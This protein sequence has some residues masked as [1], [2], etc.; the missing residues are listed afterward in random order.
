MGKRFFNPR[1][2]ELY[3]EGFIN[4]KKLLVLGASHYCL[5]SNRPDAFKCPVW[6]ECTS[7]E[8]RDSSKFN[9]C[10]PAYEANG[11]IKEYG[12]KLEDT[13]E[14]EIE[15]FFDV[16]SSYKAYYNFTKF[17]QEY[18]NFTNA[19]EVW[20]KLAFVNYVQY[21]LPTTA[22]PSFDER[23][24]RN[25]DA[26]LQTIQELQP[27][28]IIVWGT[29]TRDHFYQ[30]YIQNLVDNL[31]IREDDYFWDLDYQGRHYIIINCWH[32]SDWSRWYGS[33]DN[34]YI[35]LKEIL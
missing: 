15:N 5:Q 1:V 33:L 32:P 23:D 12:V 19:E 31:S 6:E 30:S 4:G 10:C 22:T 27:D 21:F 2:G 25:F 17:F 11:W 14:I 34:F 35:A 3:E 9:T 16:P 13:A 28:I 24:V 20:N 26:F 29:K 8:I 7:M 18:F